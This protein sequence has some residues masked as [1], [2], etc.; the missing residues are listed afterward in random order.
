MGRPRGLRD[1]AQY[2]PQAGAGPARPLPDHGRR[3]QAQ[4]RLRRRHPDRAEAEGADQAPVRLRRRHGVLLP[5]GLWPRE[6]SQG[7]HRAEPRHPGRPQLRA[8][9]GARQRARHLRLG[10]PQPR[11]R[12]SRLGHRPVRHER[13]RADAGHAGDHQ[14]G[15]LHHRRSQLRR[16][17]PPPVAR[18]GGSGDRPRRVDGRRR[19]GAAQ[20]R[21]HH[22]GRPPRQQP[23]SAL[24]G[25]E[26]RRGP[27]HPR[28]PAL[29]RRP[30]R[31]RCQEQHQSRAEERQAGAVGGHRQSVLLIDAFVLQYDERPGFPGLLRFHATASDTM[32]FGAS[33]LTPPAAPR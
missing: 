9:A 29:A 12:S 13:A 20:R 24:R 27:G 5:E 10:R 28:R 8:R 1:A 4:D 3:L 33:A 19:Q 21:R 7:Q 2:R 25:L 32:P 18:P 23:R 16:Q 15:R 6:G 30:R 17:G 14:G 26:G 11:R 31:L 22:R